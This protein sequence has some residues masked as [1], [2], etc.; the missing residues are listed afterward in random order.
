VYPKYHLGNI[1]EQTLDK[2]VLSRQQYKF[3]M[4]KKKGLPQYCRDCEYLF[5]CYGECPKNRFIRS[6][7]GEPGLNYLCS[8]L[9]K[10]F[11]HIKPYVEDMTH[12]IKEHQNA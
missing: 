7:V 10:Y 5:A 1:Q 2:M 4:D 3:G 12:Q 6:P 8:G 9:K 11:S